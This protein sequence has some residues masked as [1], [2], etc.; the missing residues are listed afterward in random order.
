MSKSLFALATVAMMLLFTSAYYTTPADGRVGRQ[1]PSLT[2]E[3]D[4]GTLSLSQLRGNYVVVTFWSSAQPDSRISNLQLK[5]ATS[6]TNVKHFAVNMDE[7]QAM[8]EQ[9]VIADQLSGPWQSHCD[10]D[11]QDNLRRSWRQ[12]GGYCSFL[13]DPD[14]RIIQKNPTPQDLERL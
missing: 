4:H 3:S 11:A 1:A 7:S 12:D 10:S 13:V 9:L 8:Y 6:N 14:G 5:R 2:V